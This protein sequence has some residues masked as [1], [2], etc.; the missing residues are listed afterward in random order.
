MGLIIEPE[1]IDFIIQSQP[2]TDEERKEISEFIEHKK[3][4][5]KSKVTTAISKK[6]SEKNL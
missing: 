5:N 3:Q 4:E 2:L 1:G 6:T